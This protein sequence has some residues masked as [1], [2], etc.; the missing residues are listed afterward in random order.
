MFAQL[1]PEGVRRFRLTQ[2]LSVAM[3]AALLGVLLWPETPVFV[4]LSEVAKG[5]GGTS[6]VMSLYLPRNGV[7][8]LT[9]N[10]SKQA[11][12][13]PGARRHAKKAQPRDERLRAPLDLPPAGVADDRASEGRQA[14]SESH[15]LR[16][17]SPFGSLADGP[18]T[19]PEVKP[20]LPIAG[21]NPIIT[22]AELPDGVEGS[23]IIE[24]TIDAQ[25]NITNK[26]VVQRF[27]YG[28]DERVLKALEQWRFRPATRDGVAIASQQLC[29][30]HFPSGAG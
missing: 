26:K 29:V 15:G 22:R 3:H 25:G 14:D 7:N 2:L 20:A 9:P 18:L 13:H 5:E 21:P 30:F 28:V 23:V 6:T 8:D 11:E 27:G 19:G 24:I 12:A 16:A 17:G 10:P 1:R 4:S